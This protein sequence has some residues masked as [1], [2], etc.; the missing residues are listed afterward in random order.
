MSEMTGLGGQ[1]VIGVN[2]VDGPILVIEGG[3]NVGYDEVVEVTDSA[4]KLRRGRVL[5]VG[6]KASVV[7]VFSG[8]TGLTVEGTNVRFLGG[9][10]HIP[11]T[12]EMLGRVFDGLGTP[13]AASSSARL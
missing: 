10:L 6:E 9:P 2:R 1:E 11:V 3:V 12:E 13:N 4:G 8:T 7:E 5:E